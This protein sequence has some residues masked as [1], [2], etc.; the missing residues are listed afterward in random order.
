MTKL[1]GHVRVDELLGGEL[2]DLGFH[3]LCGERHLDNRI[4]NPRVQ[5]PGL[6]FAG[7]YEYIKPGRVQ[8]VGESETE[9]LRRLPDAVRSDRFATIAELEIPVFIITKGLQAF[10]EFLDLCRARQ[11][12]V[13]SS[14]ALSSVIITQ[15]S[16]FLEE[17]LVPSTT[18]HAVMLGEAVSAQ[19]TVLEP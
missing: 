7:Y 10:P 9:F 15:V 6:A 12:P 13:L 5:K 16:N 14:P 17:H 8:I 1:P 2:T 18:V 19:I 11:L 3:I 4:L